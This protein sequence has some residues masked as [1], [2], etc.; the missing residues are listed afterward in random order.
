[1]PI[2]IRVWDDVAMTAP[3]LAPRSPRLGVVAVWVVSLLFAVSIG[4]FSPAG[5]R[6]LWLCVALGACLIVTF[7]LQVFVGRA[8]GFIVRVSASMLGSLLIMGIVSLGFAIA[9]VAHF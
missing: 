2:R 7:A 9:A 8:Q 5:D 1:M 6:A 3:Q 4:F